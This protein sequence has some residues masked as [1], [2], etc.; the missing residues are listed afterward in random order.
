MINKKLVLIFII[1]SL[2]FIFVIKNCDSYELINNENKIE[3]YINK[4]NTNLTNKQYKLIAKI[5]VRESFYYNLPWKLTLAIMK[6]ESNFNPTAVG[7]AGEKG[8]MQIYTLECF[9]IKADK[10]RLFEIEYNIS[11]G[12]CIL[13]DKL[14]IANNDI[15]KA[16]KLYNGSGSPARKYVLKVLNT[17]NKIDKEIK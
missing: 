4:I 10:S 6:V 2:S 3:K 16:I 5:I 8:L 7:V 15:Y 12:L 13:Q 11:F 17:I 14:K 9:G 1:I